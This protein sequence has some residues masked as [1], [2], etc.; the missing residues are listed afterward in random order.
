MIGTKRRDAGAQ[1]ATTTEPEALDDPESK[2]AEIDR[3]E[4]SI[5][6]L[7]SERAELDAS[8]QAA[9]TRDVV[10]S[11]ELDTRAAGI[12][13]TVSRLRKAL[14]DAQA[15][16]E[17]ARIAH[18][19]R[20]IVQAQAAAIAEANDFA[21][22]VEGALDDLIECWNLVHGARLGAGH[23]VAGVLDGPAMLQVL[24]DNTVQRMIPGPD[25]VD[26]EGSRMA[27]DSAVRSRVLGLLFQTLVAKRNLIE[28]GAGVLT[29][30]L[31][32]GGLHGVRRDG[33][34][35]DSFVAAVDLRDRYLSKTK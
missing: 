29:A 19:E 10:T 17:E 28:R 30:A 12:G 7:E 20:R 16:R 22:T 14:G 32:S 3:L 2:D 8:A 9:V 27:V 31:R 18:E 24:V 15:A 26:R 1:P 11:I 13:R 4:R 34:S 5:A 35:L 23:Q 21:R 33:E 6:K 25:G